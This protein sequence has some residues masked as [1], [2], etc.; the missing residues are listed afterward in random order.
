M[1]LQED[2]CAIECND[3]NA[4]RN[5]VPSRQAFKVGASNDGELLAFLAEHLR[6]KDDLDPSMVSE[7]E[8]SLRDHKEAILALPNEPLAAEIGATLNNLMAAWTR[9][10]P[11][12]ER[13][14]D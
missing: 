13:T 4:I 9:L 11:W 7:V 1:K 10:R 3:G 14:S 5:P 8:I 6:S 12:I 2:V